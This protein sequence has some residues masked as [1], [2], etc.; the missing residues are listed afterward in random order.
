MSSDETDDEQPRSKRVRRITLGW[1]SPSISSLFRAVDSYYD[2]PMEGLPLKDPRGNRAHP[3]MYD[4]TKT[5]TTRRTLPGLPVNFYNHQWWVTLPR[6]AQ[7]KLSPQPSMP[8]PH[9]VRFVFNMLM[10]L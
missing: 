9:L 10:C 4:S 7:N 3:R 8:I 2:D 1:I 6:H 5:D